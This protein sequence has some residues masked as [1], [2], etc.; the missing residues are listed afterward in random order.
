M[1]QHPERQAQEKIV[2]PGCCILNCAISLDSDRL[3]LFP[4]L[5][6]SDAAPSVPPDCL[7]GFGPNCPA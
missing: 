5:L 3:F 7:S 6:I 2:T 4:T 1:T